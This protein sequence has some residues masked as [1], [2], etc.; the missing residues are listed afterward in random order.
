MDKRIENFISWFIFMRWMAVL[1]AI[2]LV[3]IVVRVNNWLPMKV[4]DPLLLTIG[5]LALLNIVYH[6]IFRFSD[7][8]RYL[9]PFQAYADLVVL[10]VLLHYSGGIENPL[11]LLLLIHVIISGIV[12]NRRHLYA[13]TAT[14]ISLLLVL[15][16]T[17]GMSFVP[18]YT[19]NIF[20]HFAIAGTHIHAAHQPLYV[21]SFVGMMVTILLLTT[22]F[23]STIMDRIYNDERKLEQF[24]DRSLEQRQLIEKALETTDTG[25][26]LCNNEGY[27][28][29]TNQI[30]ESWFDNKSVDKLNVIKNSGEAVSISET[31]LSSKTQVGELT[32]KDED[33][34]SE[35]KNHIYQVTTAPLFDKDGKAN[36]T[37]SL[38]KDITDQKKAQDQMI[39]AGKLAAVGELAGKVAHEVNNPVTILSAKCRLLLS[40]HHDEMSEKVGRELIKI[41]EAA[42]RVADIAQG[43]LSY[44]RTSSP[45]RAKI[46][47]ANSIR[48]AL[49]LIEESARRVGVSI[50]NQ[51]PDKLPTVLGNEDELQQVFM[52]LFLNALDAMPEG[53]NLIISVLDLDYSDNIK[54]NFL[55]VEV[56][57][58][59]TGIPTKIQSRIFEPFFT[60][61]E[62]GKGT[63]LG[64]SICSG[65]IRSHNGTIDLDSSPGKGTRVTV[66]FP[67]SKYE[68]SGFPNG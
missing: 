44:C 37:V 67:I 52:N 31:L 7:N 56:R 8:N 18:H 63:G 47:I 38:A 50:K 23:I 34:N 9:L 19:L 6:L 14:A 25:L 40:D 29:W 59:G 13:I 42:D 36:R 48:N 57:D 53:G 41:T 20:P 24:A 68:K 2:I 32:L 61:K 11:T 16:I 35:G 49:S 65:I 22:F 54:P 3:F 26:C 55:T 33:R 1:M 28:Y 46:N 58:T 66:S 62:E 27:P 43:L 39:R 64:L 17:E 45:K 15:A 51:L 21:I 5:I 10:I 60:T 4:W 30:W 12:L